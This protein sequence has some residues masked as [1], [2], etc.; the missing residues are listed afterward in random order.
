MKIICDLNGKQ[1][2]IEFDNEEERIAY[3]QQQEEEKR[4]KEEVRINE[5]RK[6]FAEN[7]ISYDE[8]IKKIE[9][10]SK[11]AEEHNDEDFYNSMQSLSHHLFNN[12]HSYEEYKEYLVDKA[13]KYV[14]AVRRSKRRIERALIKL[15]GDVW[16]C[17]VCQ[18]LPDNF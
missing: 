1:T 18:N 10:Y 15:Q 2:S 6:M 8:H 12:I 13:S 16:H 11:C 3:V 4:Q 5:L 7:D 17:P 14:F 9:Y